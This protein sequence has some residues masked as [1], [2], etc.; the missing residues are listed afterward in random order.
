MIRVLQLA[1]II[2]RNDFIDVIVRRADPGRFLIGVCVR[3]A[4]SNIADPEYAGTAIPFWNLRAASRASLPLATVRLV[5]ILRQWKPDLLHAHH[6]EQALLGCIAS[7]ICP[8][9]RLVIGR[10]YSDAIYR[11]TS[12]R[13]RRA[14]LTLEGMSNRAAARIIV[15]AQTVSEILVRKQKVAADKIDVV[16]YAFDPVKYEDPP[17]RKVRQIKQELGLEGRFV[18][19]TFARLHSEK[20]H[21]YLLEAATALRGRIPGLLFLI[22][23]DGP[24]RSAIER[25]IQEKGLEDIVHLTGHRRDAMALMAA[26][27]LVVQPTLHEAFSQ[28]MAEAMWMRKPLII[29]DVSGALDIVRDGENGILVPAGNPGA[30]SAALVRVCTNPALRDRLALNGREFVSRRLTPEAVIPLYEQCYCRALG[31]NPAI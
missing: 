29:S 21:R 7:R 10:H 11:L 30:L 12:G 23:G 13:R 20:G 26:V 17:E 27:D 24:E 1:D 8:H 3:S 9:T 31:R 6:Y 22:V 2:N 19:A 14:L 28:V 16:P 15:P 18:A 4:E 25:L 5:R